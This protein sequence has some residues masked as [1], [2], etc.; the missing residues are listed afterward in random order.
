MNLSDM[1]RLELK[2]G[3][4][5]QLSNATGSTVVRCKGRKPEDLPAG[6]IFIAYGPSSSLLMDSDTA[7]SG[8]PLS[9]HMQV[10]VTKVAA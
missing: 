6:M 7:G 1:A 4:Q 5:V 8:M 3:D 10:T 9:K 2:D